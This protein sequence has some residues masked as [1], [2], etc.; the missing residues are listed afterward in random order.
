MAL[1]KTDF[2][3][4]DHRNQYPKG[5][6]LV[7][8]NWT[9]RKS[10]LEDVDS[11]VFLGLQRALI[12]M[13]RDWIE[14]FFEQPLK[15][16]VDK[17]KRRMECAGINIEYSH[18]EKLHELGYLPLEIWAVQEGASTPIG[19]AQFVMW[20][21]EPDFFWLTNYLETTLSAN[22]WPSCT[23]A[24][25]AKRYRDE[26]TH[27][28]KITGGAPEFVDFQAHDFSYRGMMGDDAAEMTGLGHLLFFNGT[29]TIPAI[30][31]AERYYYGDAE[32]I[33]GSVPATEHSVMCMG[34]KDNEIETFRRLITEIYPTGIV[35][36]VSDTWD[37]WKVWTEILPA[38]KD[39]IMARDGKV[40]IRP[41]SGDPVKI[42]TG[43]DDAPM[44]SPA[45]KGSFM[46]AWELF[47]GTKNSKGFVE[48][49]PHIGL[50]Y[51]DSITLERCQDICR[52][53]A[54]QG[55]VPNMVLGVGSYTYQYVTRD[56]FGFAL[57]ST[58]GVVNGQ[59]REIFKDPVTDDGTK[60]SAKGFV[61]VYKDEFGEY[62]MKEVDTLDKVRRSDYIRVF[63]DGMVTRRCNFDR[64]RKIAREGVNY[65]K[66]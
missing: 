1:H 66:C 18:V 41:D 26:L 6:E 28:A 15:Q 45:K 57:K 20:N 53:A 56:T 14:N 10:R 25:L 7:F 12:K 23:A 40:V 30:D 11:V 3:K 13:N 43:D 35:S 37:Y 63:A 24:T 48:L 31:A 47:G 44:G 60:K 39:D 9:P 32:T 33:G 64:M 54:N 21:T 52:R 62:T 65:G 38:L 19:V 42:L 5:T 34:T 50:I 58:A 46:L 61:A 36:I 16:V 55:F 51:G 2:Y 29:D 59:T 17:Y 49:D 27:Y 8:S 22:L 4:A